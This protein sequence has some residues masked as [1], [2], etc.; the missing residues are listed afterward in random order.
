M[1]RKQERQFLL[2]TDQHIAKLKKVIARERERIS[3]LSMKPE[4]W[5]EA[6]S[7]LDALEESLSILRRHREQ[8]RG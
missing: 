2:E 6:V 8:L 3:R 1:D 4:A 7:I 5:K